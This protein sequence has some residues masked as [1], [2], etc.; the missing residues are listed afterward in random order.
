MQ[1]VSGS[2]EGP[3]GCREGSGFIGEAQGWV[4][5]GRFPQ[6]ALGVAPTPHFTAWAHLHSAVVDVVTVLLRA[7]LHLQGQHPGWPV[8]V[9]LPGIILRVVEVVTILLRA[10]LHLQGQHPEWHTGTGLPGIILGVVE[11]VTI[12]FW[13]CLD[14]GWAPLSPGTAGEDL[15]TWFTLL[16]CPN[17]S[18]TQDAGRG[19]QNQRGKVARYHPA[20]G[21][22][23]PDGVQGPQG[24]SPH[25]RKQQLGSQGAKG[26]I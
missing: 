1:Q 18:Y 9:S 3:S 10:I 24:D 26:L 4:G 15:Y 19:E 23:H 22:S 13:Y 25:P 12:L 5:R 14:L 16:R 21:E 20:P 6:E 11:V 7:V 2:N 17:G 8:G